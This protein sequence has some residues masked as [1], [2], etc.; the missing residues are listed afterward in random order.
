[1]KK[2]IIGIVVLVLII[3]A[4]AGIGIFVFISRKPKL[5]E[6]YVNGNTPGNLYN[7]GMF[8]EKDG[9]V[10]FSNPSDGYKLYSMNALGGDL[11]AL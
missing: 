6:G 10:F 5:N 7:E 11:K 2:K 9:I 3:A 1:M 8:C 4:V